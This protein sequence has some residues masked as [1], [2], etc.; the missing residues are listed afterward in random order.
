MV[1]GVVTHSYGIERYFESRSDAIAW[2]ET[3]AMYS[4]GEELFSYKKV[5]QG[6]YD[7]HRFVTDNEILEQYKPSVRYCSSC[8]KN[9]V[10]PMWANTCACCGN[11]FCVSDRVSRQL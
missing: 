3:A 8:E 6:L 7:G 1:N 11:K 2:F 10:S 9:V 5:I 4:S